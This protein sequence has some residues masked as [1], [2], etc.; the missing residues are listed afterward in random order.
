MASE[1]QVAKP[2]K[3]DVERI[4]SDGSYYTKRNKWQQIHKELTING[5]PYSVWRYP[6]DFM[7]SVGANHV[8]TV[9]T[10]I[11]GYFY[12]IKLNS[13]LEIV[14]VGDQFNT[15]DTNGV[16]PEMLIEAV[17]QS[18]IYDFNHPEILKAIGE[19]SYNVDSM[20]D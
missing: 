20:D 9:N 15:E 14:T 7:N 3:P 11:K 8:Y 18:H 17:R 1:S 2:P 16:S 6:Q 13:N 10:K 12:T 5:E 19:T 4:L